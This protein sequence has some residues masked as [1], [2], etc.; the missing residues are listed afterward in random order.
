MNTKSPLFH[1]VPLYDGRS[2]TF[3]TIFWGIFNS[4]IPS[5][6]KNQMVCKRWSNESKQEMLLKGSFSSEF[7]LLLFKM[8]VALYTRKSCRQTWCK[9]EPPLKKQNL[10]KD[11]SG[12]FPCSSIHLFLHLDCVYVNVFYPAAPFPQIPNAA[13]AR[14]GLRQ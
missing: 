9:S 13:G 12:S 1:L 6:V 2:V 11:E 4:D 8:N 14:S 10:R 7:L 5:N 3:A